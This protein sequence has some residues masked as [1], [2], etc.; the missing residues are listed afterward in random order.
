MR[1]SNVFAVVA[2][3]VS[4]TSV[5]GL[6]PAVAANVGDVAPLAAQSGPNFVNA[7]SDAE[8]FQMK[9]AQL[10]LYKAQRDDVK[11]YAKSVIDAAQT[12]HKALLASLKNNQRT[13][14]DPAME[15]SAERAA[16][17]KLL[18]KAP[19]GSFD[20]L[21]LQQSVKVAKSGW[22]INKGYALD[23]TDEAL[24][25]VATTSVPTFEQQVEQAGSLLPAALTVAQ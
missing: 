8:L 25:Q 7:A 4:A 20:T 10:A 6:A 16:M 12:Q 1:N 18:S 24:K 3:V 15:L 17:L 22:S 21:Y 23:G 14:H 13:I 9:A 19:K 2:F 5:G 11:A